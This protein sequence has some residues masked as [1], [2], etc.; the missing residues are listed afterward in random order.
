MYLRDVQSRLVRPEKEMKA[1][2]RVAL[3]PGE[4][5]TVTLTLDQEALSYYDPAVKGWVAEVG[6]FQ[7]VVG[8]SSRDTRLTASF[9]YKGSWP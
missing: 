8:S 9:N 2:A 5:K 1:F 7:V 6:E 4:T 3:E